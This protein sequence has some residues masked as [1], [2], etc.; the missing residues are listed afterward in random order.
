MKERPELA[1]DVG[2]W[3]ILRCYDDVSTSRISGFD[4][5]GR[6][7]HDVVLRWAAH[8][9]LPYHVTNHLWAVIRLVD[10]L[11]RRDAKKKPTEDDEEEE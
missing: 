2:T 3:R 6:V 10:D 9:G 7:A 11:I 5:M 1:L 8:H 4:G